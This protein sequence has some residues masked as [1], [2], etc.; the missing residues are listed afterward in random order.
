MGNWFKLFFRNLD[1]SFATQDDENVQE[2]AAY[3]IHSEISDNENHNTIPDHQVKDTTYVPPMFS[4]YCNQYTQPQ[5]PR[6][7]HQGDFFTPPSFGPTDQFPNNFMNVDP[8][9]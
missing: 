9:G 6:Q 5:I 3:N 4:P 2:K 8:Y 7:Y 1:A